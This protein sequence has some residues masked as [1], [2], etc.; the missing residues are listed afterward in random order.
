MDPPTPLGSL[1]RFPREVRD[2]I[3]SFVSGLLMDK[4]LGDSLLTHCERSSEPPT[5]VLTIAANVT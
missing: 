5:R 3:Y 1:G 2:A 4:E